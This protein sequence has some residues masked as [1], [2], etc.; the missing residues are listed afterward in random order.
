M[1]RHWLITSTTYGTWLPGD[2]R[3]FVSTVENLRGPRVRHNQSGTPYDADMPELRE[4]AQHLLKGSPIRF[5]LEQAGVVA[6][7]FRETAA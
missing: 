2:V 4:S 6:A 7:Q 1:V 5:N 3:G